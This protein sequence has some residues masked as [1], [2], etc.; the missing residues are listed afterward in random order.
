MKCYCV[1]HRYGTWIF[2]MLILDSTC[3]RGEKEGSVG[4]GADR[5][6]ACRD[7]PVLI[8]FLGRRNLTAS[9]PTDGFVNHVERFSC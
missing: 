2:V 3:S 6:R 1:V 4:L 8:V 7:P 5:F 9:Q